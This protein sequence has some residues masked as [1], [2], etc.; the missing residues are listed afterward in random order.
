MNAMLAGG[1]RIR[2]I[3]C[4]LEV[5][6]RWQ[7]KKLQQVTAGFPFGA[8]FKTGGCLNIIGFIAAYLTV[9]RQS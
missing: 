8:Q 5:A 6:Y 4:A 7:T 1:R 3:L 9:Y 2:L